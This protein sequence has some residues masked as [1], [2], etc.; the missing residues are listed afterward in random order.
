MDGPG[1]VGIYGRFVDV[2]CRPWCVPVGEDCASRAQI[3]RLL[4]DYFV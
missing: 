1:R 4:L 3:E 2:C